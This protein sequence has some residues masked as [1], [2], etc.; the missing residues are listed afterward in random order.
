MPT[1]A[2]RTRRQRPPLPPSPRQAAVASRAARP[3][4]V[5]EPGNIDLARQPKVRNPDGS[6]STV[7]SIGLNLDGKEYLLPTVTPDGRHFVN[8]AREMGIPSNL[9]G[10]A[11]ADMAFEEFRKTGR[12]LGVFATPA[13]SDAYA[14]HLH[15]AYARGEFDTP[16]PRRRAPGSQPR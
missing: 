6:I 16:R 4:G 10:Q 1:S 2:T 13:D 15:D 14:K 3:W 7:D 8:D 12:H 9:L 5:L 11:V